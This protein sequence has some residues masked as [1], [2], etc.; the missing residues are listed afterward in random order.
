ML[1]VLSLVEMLQCDD[2][3]KMPLPPQVREDIDRRVI[4]TSE[5]AS[6]FFRPVRVLSMD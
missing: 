1:Q 3:Q 6:L 5:A 2:T 4:K